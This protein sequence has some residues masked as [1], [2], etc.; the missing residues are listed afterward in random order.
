MCWW[1][2]NILRHVNPYHDYNWDVLSVSL[3]VIVKSQQNPAHL[4]RTTNEFRNWQ[5]WGCTA[6]RQPGDQ[7]GNHEALHRN[8][9]NVWGP[10]ALAH[11]LFWTSHTMKIKKHVSTWRYVSTLFVNRFLW[12]WRTRF[13][14]IEKYPWYLGSVPWTC[15]ERPSKRPWTI[16]MWR[17][18]L[19]ISGPSAVVECQTGDHK[20]N[21]QIFTTA[22]ASIQNTKQCKSSKT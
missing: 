4:P 9:G 5:T 12:L 8:T 16:Q 14:M 7:R 18:H 19:Q 1:N 3:S 15:H 6:K 21:S 17:P 20:Q 2:D 13:Q 22:L 11:V 10:Q